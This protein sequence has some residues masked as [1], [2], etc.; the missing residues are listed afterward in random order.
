M[1]VSSCIT[2]S[3][4]LI[5]DLSFTD[6]GAH[7]FSKTGWPASCRDPA[8][9]HSLVVGSQVEPDLLGGDSKL[10]SS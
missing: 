7:Q 3:Y 8:V 10:K 2:L 4:L 9:S 6:H 5:Q 1:P